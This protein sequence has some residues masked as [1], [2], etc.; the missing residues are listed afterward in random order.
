MNSVAKIKFTLL[1]LHL[2]FVRTVQGDAAKHRQDS[3]R[4]EEEKKLK[5]KIKKKKKKDKKETTT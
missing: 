3:L 4:L 5:K 1:T 2:K